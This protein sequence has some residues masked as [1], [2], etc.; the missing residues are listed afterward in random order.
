MAACHIASSSS[1]PQIR[2]QGLHSIIPLTSVDMS[3][4]CRE[5]TRLVASFS[6]QSPTG[7][8]WGDLAESAVADQG[9]QDVD[10]AAS[11]GDHGLGMA[12]ALGALAVVKRPGVGVVT[13]AHQGGHVEDALKTPVTV[14]RPVQFAVPL[15]GI[16]R[17]RSLTGE[18]RGPVRAAEVRQVVAHRGEELG[19]QQRT[20]AGHAGH[21]PGE[22]VRPEPGLDEPVAEV[23][24]L[25]RHVRT[26]VRSSKPMA[27]SSGS[28][29]R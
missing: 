7:V 27:R 21:D 19:T 5:G 16:V 18:G 25:S 22:L 8:P 6:T 17:C 20:D 9:P 11:E 24:R 15:P 10:S 2:A 26:R 13:H 29:A 1:S 23:D 14:A 3:A 12:F 4:V 28:S